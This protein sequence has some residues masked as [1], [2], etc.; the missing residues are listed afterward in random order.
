MNTQLEV[1]ASVPSVPQHT[2]KI[3]YLIS[4]LTAGDIIYLI[5]RVF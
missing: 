5:R 2:K 3:I 1:E 4:L